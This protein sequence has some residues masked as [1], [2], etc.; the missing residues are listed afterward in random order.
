[1]QL[2]AIEQQPLFPDVICLTRNGDPSGVTFPA[3][4]L[5]FGQDFGEIAILTL[6]PQ[7]PTREGSERDGSAGTEVPHEAGRRI[8][9]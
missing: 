8:P 2:I 4:T 5:F 9:N 6:D 3:E 7:G 1:M